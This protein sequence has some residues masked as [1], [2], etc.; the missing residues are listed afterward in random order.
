MIYGE[1]RMLNK[2]KDNYT[3]GLGG[4]P[5]I[6]SRIEGKLR[7]SCASAPAPSIQYRA[8]NLDWRLVSYMILYMFQCHSPKS[9]HPLPLP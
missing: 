9:S 7:S 6:P 8:L 4:L 1:D 2:Y 5:L 3:T